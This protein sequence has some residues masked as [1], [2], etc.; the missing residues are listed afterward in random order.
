MKSIGK[1]IVILILFSVIGGIQYSQRNAYHSVQSA[2]YDLYFIPEPKYVKML[3]SGFTT[4][5]ADIYWIKTVIYFGKRTSSV[6][7][8]M[9]TRQ[10][11]GGDYSKEYQEWKE[12][13]GHRYTWLADMI[14]TVVELDPYFTY[15]YL[16]GGLMISMKAGSPEKSVAL[17]KKGLTYFSDDWQFYF[18]LGFNYYF[19]INDPRSALTYFIQAAGF[20]DCPEIVKS[21]AAVVYKDIGRRGVAIEFMKS[22]IEQTKDPKLRKEMEKILKELQ[23]SPG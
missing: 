14:N 8:P 1:I 11:L 7:F 5:A 20:P 13:A 4:L 12:D 23:K 9:I 2:E 3:A 16:F 19:Y 21:L 10:L 17:L 15:P 18:L 6:D 22:Q